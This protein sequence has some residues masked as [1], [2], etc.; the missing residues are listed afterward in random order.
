MEPT[1][2]GGGVGLLGGL[3]IGLL[4]TMGVAF[5]ASEFTSSEPTSSQVASPAIEVPALKQPVN[6]SPDETIEQQR[7]AAKKTESRSGACHPSYSGCLKPN[8]GDYDCAGGSGNG[9]NYTGSVRVT[10]PDVFDLDRDNDGW[11]CE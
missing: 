7:P 2:K 3:G 5:A 8:A 10:G 1:K 4:T 11:G 6:T 9:P